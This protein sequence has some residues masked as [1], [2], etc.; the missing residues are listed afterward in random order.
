MPAAASGATYQQNVKDYVN[1]LVANGITPIVEMHWN[2]GQYTGVGAGCSDVK[3]TCQKPMPDAQY[4]PQFWTSMANTFKDDPVV[5]D[6]FNEPYPDAAANWDA[7]PRGRAGATAAPVPASATRWPAS[8]PWSTRSGP[9]A[10]P[11]WSWSA[12]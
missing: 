8:R 4:A 12:G 1:L 6:L 5:F 3:A 11:T 9:P 7:T 2:Y 10:P